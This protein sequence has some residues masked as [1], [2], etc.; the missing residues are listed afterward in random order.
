MYIPSTAII[1]TEKLTAYLLVPRRKS[2]KSQYLARAGF[3]ATNPDALE[4]ALRQL[5]AEYEA[6]QDRQDE[7]GT[8]YRVS[9]ELRGPR[10]ILSVVTVWMLRSADGQYRFITLKPAR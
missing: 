9:G 5:I 8:F 1:P 7:Y 3:T 2:D 4:R 6:I 10:G